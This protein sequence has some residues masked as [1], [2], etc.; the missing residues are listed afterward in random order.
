MGFDCMNE[1]KWAVCF[2]LGDPL[3]ESL[4]ARILPSLELLPLT[5]GRYVG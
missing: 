4:H 1:L 3:A 2:C 5:A